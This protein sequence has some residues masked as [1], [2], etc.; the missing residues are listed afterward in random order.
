MSKRTIS[1]M[2]KIMMIF[3]ALTGAVCL[4]MMRRI[5]DYLLPGYSLIT[6]NFWLY[7]LY[8]CAV[9]CY[10]ALY[11]AWRIAGN[12]G[13]NHSFCKENARYMTFLGILMLLV[14][15]MLFS[16]NLV[17][18]LMGRSFMAFFFAFFFIIAL[19]FAVTVCAFSLS[20]LL[21]NASELQNQSDFTI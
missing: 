12:I 8:G 21:D 17:Y 11:P 9:P 2:M 1:V 10:I 19:F 6:H 18:F 13:K 5:L 7:A 16:T 20:S 3:I 15:V 4:I 14:T